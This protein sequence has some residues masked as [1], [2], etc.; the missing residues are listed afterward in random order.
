[1]AGRSGHRPDT[2]KT[3]VSI[4]ARSP[5]WTS[6]HFTNSDTPRFCK[7]LQ[8]ECERLGVHF[9]VNST[10]TRVF[11]DLQEGRL[12]QV[13]IETKDTAQPIRL[14]CRNLVIS[15]GSCSDVV[16]SHLF[17]QARYKIPMAKAQPAQNWLRLRRKRETRSGGHDD[18]DVCQQVWLA[19]ALPDN[20]DIHFSDDRYGELYG[21]GEFQYCE[22]PYD[23]SESVKLDPQELKVLQILSAR[24]L[25]L[26]TWRTI[27]TRV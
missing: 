26:R 24:Y 4:H 7:F 14:P 17:P 5:S 27:G 1:M 16:F 6:A 12:S 22:P 25:C 20:E 23:L 19:P 18:V 15:A 8:D 9:L 2:L 11:A 3:P 13:E 10:V 21:A